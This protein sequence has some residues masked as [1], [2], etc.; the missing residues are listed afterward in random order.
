MIGTGLLYTVSISLKGQPE[1]L[2][3]KVISLKMGVPRGARSQLV[4][5]TS[6]YKILNKLKQGYGP[7]VYNRFLGQLPPNNLKTTKP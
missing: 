1:Q 6:C 7:V 2:S 4:D 3:L 5:Q